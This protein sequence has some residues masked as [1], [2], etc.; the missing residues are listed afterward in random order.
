MFWHFI[1]HSVW[2]M[3]WHMY[4]HFVPDTFWHC[5]YIYNA[6]YLKCL[7]DTLPGI[8]FG[9]IR[10][11]QRGNAAF[12]SRD[13]HLVGKTPV[14][15][16][17]EPVTQPKHDNSSTGNQWPMSGDIYL[18]IYSPFHLSICLAVYLS[19]CLSIYLSICLPVYVCCSVIQCNVV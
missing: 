19:I 9:I 17:L 2:H 11:R 14:V 8:L 10:G 7:S 5:I 1:W 6:F 18:S 3:F 4:W 13:P 12:K 16:M 15:K